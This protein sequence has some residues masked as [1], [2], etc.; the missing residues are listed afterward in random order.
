MSNDEERTQP[1]SAKSSRTR[2]NFRFDLANE[3]SLRKNLVLDYDL[4]IRGSAHQ[5]AKFLASGSEVFRLA[6]GV[7]R[8]LIGVKLHH[9]IMVRPIQRLAELISLATGFVCAHLSAQCLENLFE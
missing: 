5:S 7:K 2:T 4:N 3:D 1:P 9:H 6:M 8:F